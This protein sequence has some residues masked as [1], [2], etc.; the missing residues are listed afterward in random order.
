MQLHINY[1]PASNRLL[2]RPQKSLCDNSD[3]LKA[4]QRSLTTFLPSSDLATFTYRVPLIWRLASA[5]CCRLRSEPSLWLS[6]TGARHPANPFLS[7][8][9]GRA[10]PPESR[11]LGHNE[12]YGRSGSRGRATRLGR[13]PGGL[14]LALPPLPD[15]WPRSSADSFVKRGRGSLV[16]AR[17]H[18]CLQWPRR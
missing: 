17:P 14:C 12:S 18:S 7:G 1:L 5:N 8:A 13:T 16:P 15:P 3:V 4:A 2:N 11:Q 9:G 10:P 6:L